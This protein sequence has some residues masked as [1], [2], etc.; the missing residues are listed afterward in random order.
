M[1][2]ECSRPACDEPLGPGAISDPSDPLGRAWCSDECA[3]AGSEAAYAQ[4]YG[5]GV[6]T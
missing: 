3:D 1:T 4:M 2:G 6:A 5:T